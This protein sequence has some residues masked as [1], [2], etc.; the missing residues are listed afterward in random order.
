MK[1]RT[2]SQGERQNGREVR[3]LSPLAIK[4]GNE[5][6]AAMLAAMLA[7]DIGLP[8]GNFW[9][10]GIARNIAARLADGLTLREVEA[11][12]RHRLGV[13]SGPENPGSE[14][15]PGCG[16]CGRCS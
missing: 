4:L 16:Y 2:L 7:Q 8:P 1:D 3:S 15:G 10:P 14:C 5:K 9:E 11:E 6:Q 12:L 13:F